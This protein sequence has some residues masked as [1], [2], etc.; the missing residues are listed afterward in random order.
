MDYTADN[1]HGNLVL[2]VTP[3]E[4]EHIREMVADHGCDYCRNCECDALEPL[5]ANSELEW[6]RP[7]E[8]AALTDAPILGIRGDE[9]PVPDNCD[10]RDLHIV[11]RWENRKTGKLTT[12]YEPVENAWGYMDYQVRSF[13]QDLIETGTATFVSGN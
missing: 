10:T 4:R 5:I 11:G 2:S 3:E 9:T 13:L 6:V 12:F 8:I 7:E 1:P